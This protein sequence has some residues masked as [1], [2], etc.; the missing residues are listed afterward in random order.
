[1]QEPAAKEREQKIQSRG[2]M[3]EPTEK[4]GEQKIQGRGELGQK[5]AAQPEKQQEARR[6]LGGVFGPMTS[7][8]HP[9][10]MKWLFTRHEK[11][12][13]GARYLEVLELTRAKPELKEHVFHQAWMK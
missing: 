7:E 13:R 2:E 8:E 11:H 9:L 3:Q 1:M 4:E 12:A 5:Q 6:D 10:L